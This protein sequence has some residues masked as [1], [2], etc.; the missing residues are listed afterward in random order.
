MN[1]RDLFGC[2][3]SSLQK[4]LKQSALGV[5][6]V[7]EEYEVHRWRYFFFLQKQHNIVSLQ[8]MVLLIIRKEYQLA[9]IP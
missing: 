2:A 4:E 5:I 1:F 7:L 6:A 9:C 8:H 3:S